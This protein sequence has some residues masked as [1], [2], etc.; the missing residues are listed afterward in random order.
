MTKKL[1]IYT[2]HLVWLEKWHLGGL[3]RPNIR[4]GWGDKEFVYTFGREI[5]VKRS[6]KD[7]KEDGKIIFNMDFRESDWAWKEDESI[8][9]Y[10]KCWRRMKVA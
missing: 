8:G 4:V 1:E 9:K 2:G 10:I 6:M 3:D 7:R 5:S